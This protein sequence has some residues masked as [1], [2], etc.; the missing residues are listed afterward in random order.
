MLFRF[1]FVTQIIVQQALIFYVRIM[2]KIRNDRTVI[3]IESPLT[4]AMESQLAQQ[5]IGGGNDM[6]K[7]LASSFLSKDTTVMEYDMKQATSL[8][9]GIVVSMF[10]M[11]FMH[12]KFEQVH[13][14]LVSVISGYV[15]LVFNPLFQVYVLG[16]NLERPFKTPTPAWLQK[17]ESET[18]EQDTPVAIEGS[19][20]D[21]SNEEVEQEEEVEDEGGGLEAEEDE[22]SDNGIEGD[23][24]DEDGA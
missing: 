22:S 24:E 12:F 15:Q 14:L 19:T 7:N 17:N 18:K 23:D 13:P 21:E 8:Q 4:A 1:L 2:A 10:I 9:T 3:H 11:W 16:R 20:G 6:I 5:Q